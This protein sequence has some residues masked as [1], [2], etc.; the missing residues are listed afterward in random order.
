MIDLS[1]Y[2]CDKCARAFSR[3]CKHCLHTADKA[4]TKFKRKNNLFR[5]LIK[6]A[7]DI[8]DAI[9]S[10]KTPEF[11]K[12]TPPPPPT[13]GS[14]VVKPKKPCTYETPCGWCCKWDKK[15][16]RKIGGNTP[17]VTMPESEAQRIIDY[18]KAGK[19]PPLKEENTCGLE[20]T[21]YD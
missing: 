4:P 14:N 3:H 11:R 15:C 8:D 19:L 6:E 9:N 18:V 21:N 10:F 20:I 1:N 2:S 5:K 13:S 16:D 7:Q 17:S 12:S